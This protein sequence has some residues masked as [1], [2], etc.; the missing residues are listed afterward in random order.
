MTPELVGIDAPPV[1]AVD[2]SPVH[3]SFGFADICGFTSF[4]E[5]EG[6]LEATRLLASFRSTAREIAGRRGVRIA[7]WL[8][9]GVM[10]VSVEAGPLLATTVELTGR[11]ESTGLDLRS[12]VATGPCVLFE[13]DDY[14]V[15]A[16]NL[17]ARLCDQAGPAD[18]LAELE[19]RT[20]PERI[21]D[22]NLR[23]GPYG[24][25]FGTR[26]DG[27]GPGLSLDVLLAHPHGVDLGSLEPRLPEMLRT[28]TGRIDLATPEIV[29]DL[30]RLE[31]RLGDERPPLVLIGRRHLRSNNSWQHNPPTLMKGRERC[32]LA[33]HPDDAAA[34]GLTDGGR[35]VVRTDRAELTV[36]VEVTDAVMAGV[37]SLPH[38]WGHDLDGARLSVASARPGVNVNRL[39]GNE[40]VDPLSG[41]PH[42]NGFPVEVAPAAD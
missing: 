28:P 41:N 37:V 35:A 34:R 17:A 31:A 15:H 27:D 13:A 24:D 38:G 8:G 29:A 25:G 26:P 2:P 6:A 42:L 3:R 12:G 19:P 22:L 10:F 14:I 40:R 9:D 16:V 5:R 18:V 36:T 1:A 4:L 7:K 30:D 32:V 20:G 39:A 23:I 11:M 33:M 21:L